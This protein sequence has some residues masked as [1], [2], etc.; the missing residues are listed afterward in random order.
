MT[1]AQEAQAA[2]EANLKVQASKPLAT[3]LP[4]HVAEA[5]RAAARMPP[6]LHRREAIDRATARASERHPN[7]FR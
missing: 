1:P 3:F 6:G 5:L 4:L 2:H 7:L